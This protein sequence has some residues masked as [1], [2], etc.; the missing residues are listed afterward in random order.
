MKAFEP[1]PISNF[2]PSGVEPSL[3]DRMKP[4]L[5]A[6]TVTVKAADSAGGFATPGSIVDVVCRR[7]VAALR[8]QPAGEPSFVLLEQVDVLA[9]GDSAFPGEPPKKA[10]TT[11]TLALTPEQV[12]LVELVEG[13]GDLSLVLRGPATT[14]DMSRVLQRRGRTLARPQRPADTAA[15]HRRHLPRRKNKPSPLPGRLPDQ[16]GRN[17]EGERTEDSKQQTEEGRRKTKDERGKREEERGKRE[18]GRGKREEGRGKTAS[19]ILLTNDYIN[20]QADQ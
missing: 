18:E 9:L 19:M 20:T 16:R 2:Y 7:G 12:D 1:F 3:S 5:R 17:L 6:V 11:V 8:A 13:R 14:G 15:I 4:G 10:A